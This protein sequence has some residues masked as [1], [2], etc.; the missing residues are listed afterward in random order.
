MHWGNK[1]SIPQ[2]A[3]P[4]RPPPY[5]ERMSFLRTCLFFYSLLAIVCV[6]NVFMGLWWESLEKQRELSALLVRWV[7]LCIWYL[8][9]AIFSLKKFSGPGCCACSWH[10]TIMQGKDRPS[11]H[12]CGNLP[13]S[14]HQ[15]IF[16]T[17]G[18]LSLTLETVAAKPVFFQVD[19]KVIK[20]DFF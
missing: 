2:P 18:D 8:I 16:R 13:A 5:A 9:N 10:V 12:T 7:Y 4:A 3:A 11:G 15:P 14:C 19:C 1:C 6:Q 20:I 17:L